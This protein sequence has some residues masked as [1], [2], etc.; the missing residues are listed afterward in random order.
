MTAFQW[1]ICRGLVITLDRHIEFIKCNLIG[2]WAEDIKGGCLPANSRGWDRSHCSAHCM[3]SRA[4][5]RE[6]I[7]SLLIILIPLC[8]FLSLYLLTE[9]WSLLGRPQAALLQG[10]PGV[11]QPVSGFPWGSP[12]FSVESGDASAWFLCEVQWNNLLSIRCVRPSYP[13]HDMIHTHRLLLMT[14]QGF[15]RGHVPW[16][17]ALLH[18]LPLGKRGEGAR[19]LMPASWE[20]RGTG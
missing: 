15:L 6:G 7:S 14:I 18:L 5:G 17:Q 3:D 16:P 10:E 20:L 9:G 4:I 13:I 1:P 2:N 12:C 8:S 11:R 19:L